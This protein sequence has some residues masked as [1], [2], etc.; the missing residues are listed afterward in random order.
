MRNTK[1]LN[2]FNNLGINIAWFEILC[3]TKDKVNPGLIIIVKRC[4]LKKHPKQR[5]VYWAA[6]AETRTKQLNV[7]IVKCNYHLFK[8]NHRENSD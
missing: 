7:T 5:D 4:Y 1:K 6:K 8:N 2:I 3:S